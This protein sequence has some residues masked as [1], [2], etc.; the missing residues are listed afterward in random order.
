MKILKN[1]FFHC[2]DIPIGFTCFNDFQQFN[3]VSTL[4]YF[5]VALKVCSNYY[6]RYINK[7]ISF[8]IILYLLIFHV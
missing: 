3:L 4:F 1:I 6:S 2:G 5:T 8:I 7:L